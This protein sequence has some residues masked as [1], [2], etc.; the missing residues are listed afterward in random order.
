MSIFYFTPNSKQISFL[1]IR[2]LVVIP[3]FLVSLVCVVEK[4]HANDIFLKCSSL[5][6]GGQ[7]WNGNISYIKIYPDKN[8]ALFQDT[9]ETTS[10][11]VNYDIKSITSEEIWIAPC[12]S[13]ECQTD[14]ID[15]K[16]I[17]RV[18]GILSMVSKQENEW[19]QVAR[20]QCKKANLF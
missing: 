8:E 6:F 19:L 20:W 7:P 2:S 18:S 17:D 11:W 14:V 12:R 16:R 13:A 9:G 3:L 1:S 10:Y 4:S 5:S 15:N